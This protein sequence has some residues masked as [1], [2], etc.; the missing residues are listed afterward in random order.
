MDTAKAARVPKLCHHKASGQGVVR[1]DGRDFYCGTY[2]TKEAQAE[3]DRLAALYLASGRRMPG[4]PGALDNPTV[5]EL[6]ARYWDFAKGYYRKPDGSASSELACVKVAVSELRRLAGD[7]P[8][9]EFGPLRLKALQEAMVGRKWVRRSINLHTGRVR[10]MFAWAVAN[11]LLPPDVLAALKAVP[12][13]KAGRCAAPDR[14]PV[15]PVPATHVEKVL[16]HLTPPVAAMV[17]LMA[18]T[19]MRVSEVAG[20]RMQ[21]VDRSG[22][23]WIYRPASHKTAWRGRDRSVPLGPQAQNILRPFLRAAPA[24]HLFQ[25]GDGDAQYRGRRRAERVTPLRPADMR[26]EDRAAA[27]SGRRFAAKY[28]KDS[29]GHAVRRACERADVPPWHVHQLRHAVATRVRQTHGLDAARAVLGHAG[30][31]V[32][33]IYAERDT[34]AARRVMASDG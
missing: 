4:R 16:P 18:L 14:E 29:V 8:A 21:D 15:R 22:E 20:M 26:R 2:G 33:L 12:G 24:A 6:I 7:L 28:D 3:Y 32:T 19:G 11:E 13:L 25:P 27:T 23:V 30:A 10:R 34:E 31:D 5:T 9:R 17:Q 1:L